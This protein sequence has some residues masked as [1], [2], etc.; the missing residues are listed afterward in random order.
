MGMLLRYNFAP[1]HNTSDNN[2]QVSV[3]DYDGA[4][5]AVRRYLEDTYGDE[6]VLPKSLPCGSPKKMLFADTNVAS[7]HG[8]VFVWGDAIR[9]AM[10]DLPPDS[11]KFLEVDGWKFKVC[12]IADEDED[13]DPN[14]CRTCHRTDC[15]SVVAGADCPG[16]HHRPA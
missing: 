5:D 6:F 4:L 9:F 16:D 7:W 2:I 13:E 3:C 10:H 15:V 14:A 8:T 11:G 12:S 1:S